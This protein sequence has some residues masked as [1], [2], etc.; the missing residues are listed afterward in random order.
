MQSST[1]YLPI[2]IYGCQELRKLIPVLKNEKIITSI[3]LVCYDLEDPFRDIGIICCCF[4][5]LSSR[6]V[7]V[8]VD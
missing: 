7:E 2:S 4:K 1:C 5:C 3:V 6:E 8:N